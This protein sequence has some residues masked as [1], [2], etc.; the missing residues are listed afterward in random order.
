MN[1]RILTHGFV[2]TIVRGLALEPTGDIDLPI[3][4]TV[5]TENT[6]RLAIA[7]LEAL[8]QAGFKKASIFTKR[9]VNFD[10]LSTTQ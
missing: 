1:G 8:G 7:A 10:L 3:L 5:D 9:P 4:L 2:D 6:H